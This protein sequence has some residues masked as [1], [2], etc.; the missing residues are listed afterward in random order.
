MKNAEKGFTEKELTRREMIGTMALSSLALSALSP[1]TQAQPVIEAEQAANNVSNGEGLRRIGEIKSK[2]G[3]L[4]GTIRITNQVRRIPGG[5]DVMLRYYEG[6]DDSGV[7][8]PPTSDPNSAAPYLPGPTIRAR[9]GDTVNLVLVNNVDPS[10]F[11]NSLDTGPGEN[12]ATGSGCDVVKVPPNPVAQYPDQVGDKYP[13]CFHA[14]STT[15]LHFHGMHVS[16]RGTADNI[17]L[18]VRADKTISPTDPKVRRAIYDVF[19]APPPQTYAQMPASW[20]NYQASLIG[21]YNKTAPYNGKRGLPPDLRL[22]IPSPTQENF[23]EWAIGVYPYNFLITPPPVQGNSYKMGQAPGTHWYHAHKHGSTATNLYNGLA[24]AF[25]IEGQY[26]DDLEKIYPD[27]RNT[28]KV[29]VFQEA[30]EAPDLETTL[31]LISP[32]RQKPPVV[33][34]AQNPVIDMRPGEIQFWRFVNAG[35]G[36]GWG[37]LKASLWDKG[38][39]VKQTAQDGVQFSWQ[40]YQEQALLE[41]D[42]NFASGNRVDW[43]VQAPAKAGDYTL[44]ADLNRTVKLL[45]LRVSGSEMNPAPQF[46]TQNN[47]P[48]FPDFLKDISDS[49][50]T[51]PGQ[52]V[53]FDYVPNPN[54]KTAPTFTIDGKQFSEDPANFIKVNVGQAQEWTVRNPTTVPFRIPHPFH[55][56][57]NPFQIVEINDGTQTF[58]IPEGKR[59]WWDTRIIP[60]GGYLKIRSRFVDFWGQY[61]LHCHILDHEDRGMMK[62]VAVEDP[63]AHLFTTAVHHH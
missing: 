63:P 32:P 39:T 13:N 1:T 50:L 26:D 33:N 37:G 41:S 58:A 8:W 36:A 27:L 46:P 49:E 60:P 55:I 4:R 19:A 52:T 28:E 5:S 61:V 59:E 48:E 24:G 45:T 31:A 21:N 12:H 10:K 20:K 11:P 47:Y 2:G 30:A 16:P 54:F 35:V 34:G 29:L 42:D 15:N 3:K 57:V 14:S 7:I 6:I 43:L 38:V 25:I 44:F 23:P 18:Q 40:S 51:P 9:I 56:H 22:P 53:T 17:F 62:V